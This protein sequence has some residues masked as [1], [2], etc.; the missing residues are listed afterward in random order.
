VECHHYENN[1]KNFF[2]VYIFILY[3]NVYYYIIISYH[4]IYI[5]SYH[6]IIICLWGRTVV[7]LQHFLLQCTHSFEQYP[8]VKLPYSTDPT[9]YPRTSS[10]CYQAFSWIN[11][12]L[13]MVFMVFLGLGHA[14][15]PVTGPVA[16]A[17]W[18]EVATTVMCVCVFRDER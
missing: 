8:N 3:V 14:G 10:L 2:N 4:I 15:T 7:Y 1:T 11:T 5:I 9:F 6:H 12:L 17:Q 16:L 13:F 18:R